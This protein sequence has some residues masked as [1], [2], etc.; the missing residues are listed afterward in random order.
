MKISDNETIYVH[1]TQV[2]SLFAIS[3]R[4]FKDSLK[5]YVKEN[6]NSETSYVE[7]FEKNDQNEELFE[8]VDETIK[9]GL[10]SI[11]EKSELFL[12][13][14]YSLYEIADDLLDEENSQRLQNFVINCKVSGNNVNPELLAAYNSFLNDDQSANSESRQQNTYQDLSSKISSMSLKNIADETVVLK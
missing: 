2:A 14:F 4:V 1:W 6:Y 5:R 8:I 9:I 13:K 12:L 11:N 7:V 3:K 10:K